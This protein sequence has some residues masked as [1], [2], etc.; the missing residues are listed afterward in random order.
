MSIL[1]S[2]WNGE[3]KYKDEYEELWKYVPDMGYTDNKYLD[4]LIIMSKM[5]YDL[6]NNG[7]CN[8]DVLFEDF[9]RHLD[10]VKEELN[11]SEKTFN[12]VVSIHT[13]TEEVDEPVYMYDEENECDTEEIDYYEKSEVEYTDDITEEDYKDYELLMDAVIELAWKNKDNFDISTVVYSL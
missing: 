5:Y 8:E 3:G 2:Y 10:A 12:N 9:E 13:H 7:L 11:I 6:Y 4:A 1:N